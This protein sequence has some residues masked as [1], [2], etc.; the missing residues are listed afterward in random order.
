M[1]QHVKGV[2]RDSLV[3]S[4]L[5][6]LLLTSL[7]TP[8]YLI[9]LWL[10]P[11]PLLILTV[12]QGTKIALIC[13]LV[14]MGAVTLI[15]PA[16]IIMCIY[17]ITVGVIMG[18]VYK[19]TKL[20]SADVVLSGIVSA[21]VAMWITLGLGERFFNVLTYLQNTVQKV[22]TEQ[23]EV[24]ATYGVKGTAVFSFESVL[25]VMLLF[26][27]AFI[28]LITFIIARSRLAKRG[29]TR[30]K[31][32]PFHTWRLSAIFIVFLVVVILLTW[33]GVFG[34]SPYLQAIEIILYMM[35]LFQGIVFSAFLLHIWGKS[36]LWIIPII[37]ISFLPILSVL[38]QM[39]GILD[40]GTSI[41]NRLEMR[42]K[43]K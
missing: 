3:Y 41:R 12:K 5:F 14:L 26:I 32:P 16:F 2:V 1:S 18:K 29:F 25:A 37:L 10:I 38:I 36:K 11:L 9:T 31:L 19:D 35:F 30:D 20:K 33:T 22:I 21:F 15:S 6:L 17:P 40:S 43:E 42:N 27:V 4:M 8:I 7:L 13:S 28:P 34:N 23:Q 24:I 39:L